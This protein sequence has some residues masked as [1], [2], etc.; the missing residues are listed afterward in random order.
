MYILPENSDSI[1]FLGILTLLILEYRPVIN[2]G[3]AEIASALP[4]K[5]LHRISQNEFLMCRSLAILNKHVALTIIV[6]TTS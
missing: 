6:S 1:N 3:T 5:P 4:L 2:C